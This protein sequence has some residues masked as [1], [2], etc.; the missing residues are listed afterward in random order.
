MPIPPPPPPPPGPPPPPTFHESNTTPPKLSSSETKGRGA[1]LSDIHKGARLRK[2]GVV[3]DRSS[4]NIEKSGGGG[5][6]GGGGS[7][8]MGMGGLFQ[9]GMP[10]LRP[11]GDGSSGGSVGRSALR[12]PGS[13]SPAPRPPSGRSASPSPPEHQRSHRPSLPDITRPPNTSSSSSGGGMKH[14]TSAPPPPPPFNRG[15]R[16]NAPPTPNLKVSAASSSAQKPLPPTPSRGPA[17]SNALKNALASSRPPTSGSSAPPPPPPYRVHTSLS[18]GPAQTDGGGAPELPQRHNSLTKKHTAQGR[19]HAPPPP[20]SP[21]PSLQVSRPPPPAREPPGRRAAP[22]APLSA[23]RN[24][25]RDAPPLP[26]PYRGHSSAPSEPPGRGVR[27][28]PPLSFSSSSLSSSSRTPA[29]PPPPP[30]PIRNG[31][32]AVSN[33]SKSILDDFESKFNF[34][35]MEDLPPPEEYRHFNKVYPSKSGKGILRGAP[36]APPVGR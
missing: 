13:R 16:G 15:G 26:P 6:G 19:N 32:S 17:P 7:G 12:P 3:N 29:G 30:P 20:P 28:P 14:S 2:V 23:S 18:N 31:H 21:S 5:G 22:Q 10:K 33:S 34:H 1:L 27:P 8:P 35:P 24:G 11:H 25:N 36:P 4:P 9:G